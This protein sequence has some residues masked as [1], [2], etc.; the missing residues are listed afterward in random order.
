MRN[1]FVTLILLSVSLYGCCFPTPWSGWCSS[2]VSYPT[3][4]KGSCYSHDFTGKYV[5]AV[6]SGEGWGTNVRMTISQEQLPIEYDKST[7]DPKN[8]C[9]SG[10]INNPE[11]TGQLDYFCYSGNDCSRYVTINGVIENGVISGVNA[12]NTARIVM[13]DWTERVLGKGLLT[14]ENIQKA[15][16]QLDFPDEQKGTVFQLVRVK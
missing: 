13:T 7:G 10:F 6:I 15:N 9:G 3:V 5:G 2:Q 8:D 12:G 4:P 1:K 14:I 11:L 16:I